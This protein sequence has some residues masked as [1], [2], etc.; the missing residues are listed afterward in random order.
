MSSQPTV[1]ETVD[2]RYLAFSPRAHAYL[3]T[4][5]PA[6]A[7]AG[8]VALAVHG[9][10][11]SLLDGVGFLVMYGLSTIGITVGFHRHFTHLAFSAQDWL[12]GTLIVLGSFC[13]QG[14]LLYWVALHRRHHEKADRAGDPHSPY[15]KRE[16]EL[17]GFERF[18]HSHVGWVFDH[19]V[20]STLHY[21]RDLLREP[22]IVRLSRLYYVWLLLGIV[23]P[24]AACGLAAGSWWAAWSGAL[25]GG[26]IR[27]IVVQNA[28]WTIT[29]LAHLIG[30][31]E[32][33]SRDQSRNIGWLSLITFGES[34]HN[35]HHA[36]PSS[37]RFGLEWWQI[38]FGGATIGVFERLGWVWE[39]KHPTA[40]QKD[41]RRLVVGQPVTQPD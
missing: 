19:D 32:Y 14:P 37:A 29:S 30:R 4:T 33:R 16:R 6:L 39:V 23:L 7:I 28:I 35:N 34:W 9:R 40:E 11:P 2:H 31:Q 5:V 36:F 13:G 17:K 1:S 15:I 27:I 8:V 22:A 26:P 3:V 38:D 18:L 21:A 20:P 10:G 41:K 12:R 25:W 24:G